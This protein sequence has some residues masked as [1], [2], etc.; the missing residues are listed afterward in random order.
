MVQFLIDHWNVV[1]GVGL[2]LL[3]LFSGPI[4]SGAKWAWSKMPSIFS[5]IRG[6]IETNVSTDDVDSLDLQAFKR[7]VARYERLGCKEGQEAMKVAGQHFLHTEGH[8]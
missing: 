5:S 2:A 6:E 7:L 3:I 4:T 1:A 8:A